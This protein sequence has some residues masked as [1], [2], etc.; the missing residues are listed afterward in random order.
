[1]IGGDLLFGVGVTG[2]GGAA[3][4][5]GIVIYFRR[6][7]TWAYLFGFLLAAFHT[8]ASLAQHEFGLAIAVGFVSL[9]LGLL[10]GTNFVAPEVG[11]LSRFA[12]QTRPWSSRRYFFTS[13]PFIALLLLVIIWETQL[14]SIGVQAGVAAVG[15]LILGCANAVFFLILSGFRRLGPSA[16]THPGSGPTQTRTPTDRRT[17]RA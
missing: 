8:F 10:V 12:N 15:G 7:M 6:L 9:T 11:G 2:L 4:F 1:M 16:P 5:F 13:L 3:I 14:V 17:S